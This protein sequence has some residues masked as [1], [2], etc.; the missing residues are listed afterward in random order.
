MGVG[1]QVLVFGA[2]PKLTLSD[3]SSCNVEAPQSFVR[4]KGYENTEPAV[5]RAMGGK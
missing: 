3:G 4:A 5:Q 1:A 2:G